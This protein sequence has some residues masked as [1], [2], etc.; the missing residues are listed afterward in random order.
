MLQDQFRDILYVEAFNPWAGKPWIR[1]TMGCSY[2]PPGN[3]EYDCETRNKQTFSEGDTY[4]MSMS[5]ARNSV[6]ARATRYSDSDEYKE[7]DLHI[8]TAPKACPSPDDECAS[9]CACEAYP[10][11]SH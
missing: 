1:L 9:D 7:F 11:Y 8:T 4:D 2:Y 3:T 5:G 6:A 10:L